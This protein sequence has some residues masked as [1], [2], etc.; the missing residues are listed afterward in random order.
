MARFAR[1]IKNRNLLDAEIA[2]REI[3]PTVAAG[4]TVFPASCSLK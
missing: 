3:R 1:T 4:R 2:A